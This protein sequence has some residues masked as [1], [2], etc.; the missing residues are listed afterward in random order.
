MLQVHQRP[1]ISYLLDRIKNEFVKEIEK[2]KV[3]IIIVSSNEEEN[4]EFETIEM[5]KINVFYG[6]KGNIQLKYLQATEKLKY[7]V[8]VSVNGDDI[9]C[10]PVAMRRCFELLTSG[11][12]YVKTSG[13]PFGMNAFGYS[14]NILK[15]SLNRK[16]SEVLETGWGRIFDEKM[17]YAIRFEPFE[18]D[19]NLRFT[20]DYQEDYLFLKTI[21]EGIGEKLIAATDKEIVQYVLDN[22]L[23]KIN[24]VFIENYWKNFQQGQDDD[25]VSSQQN[26]F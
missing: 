18:C 12:E 8:V 11:K 17:F 6:S 15:M 22:D 19:S 1:I 2:G 10:S 5:P 20:L 3:E 21:I 16:L 9:F 26:K 24:N 25:T 4:K 13:L 7:N 14:K 23:Y